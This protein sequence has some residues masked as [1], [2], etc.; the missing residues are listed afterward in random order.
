MFGAGAWGGEGKGSKSHLLAALGGLVQGHHAR[1]QLT[2]A[3][4]CSWL[5]S[6][7]CRG[8][9]QLVAVSTRLLVSF[10]YFFTLFIRLPNNS[11]ISYM[12]NF[13]NLEAWRW[14]KT[15]VGLSQMCVQLVLMG[16]FSLSLVYIY[17]P[18]ST[19]CDF[20][21]L[22]ILCKISFEAP[23]NLELFMKGVFGI[24]VP[25]QPN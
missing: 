17:P 20:L 18:F 1:W 15:N 9:W 13:F 10:L 6:L 7:V 3:A 16:L 21:G 8:S 5:T 24:I 4:A 23:T 19:S 2:H 22:S 14:Q 25:V 12:T 11:R